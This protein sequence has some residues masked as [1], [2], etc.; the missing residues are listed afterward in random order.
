MVTNVSANTLHPTQFRSQKL[1]S[2]P[3]TLRY[4]WD[5]HTIG[6]GF[7][8]DYAELPTRLIDVAACPEYPGPGGLSSYTP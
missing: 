3:S 1:M 5:T 2:Q 7:K 4:P 6:T 8:T